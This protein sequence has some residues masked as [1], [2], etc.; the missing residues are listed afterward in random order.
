MPHLQVFA[1]LLVE[2]VAEEL[3]AI[4]DLELAPC[5]L[6]QAVLGCEHAHAWAHS[7]EAVHQR[8]QLQ[9]PST[10]TLLTG[11]C[12]IGPLVGAERV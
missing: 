4:L 10:G 8:C 1:P 9:H 3:H 7:T 11:S 6:I 2:W 5:T 12:W